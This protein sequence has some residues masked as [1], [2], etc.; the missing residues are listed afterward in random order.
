MYYY[1]L[2]EISKGRRAMKK[3]KVQFEATLP[4]KLKKEGKYYISNCPI[5]DIYSQGKSK[6]NAKK[7]LV[8]AIS[9]FFISCFE[10]GKLDA[11]LKE[12]GFSKAKTSKK[13]INPKEKKLY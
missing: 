11:A 2:I 12:L 6:E 3:I 5:L 13:G 1:K 9:L 10:R 8:D 7:N 4:Y